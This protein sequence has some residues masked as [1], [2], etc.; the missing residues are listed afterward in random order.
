MKKIQE[1]KPKQDSSSSSTH[2][3]VQVVPLP[4]WEDIFPH[5]LE[6]MR[7]IEQ[8]RNNDEY[9]TNPYRYNL[10]R[11]SLKSPLGLSPLNPKRE[12][13]DEIGERIAKLEQVSKTCV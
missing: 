6:M 5:K 7:H 1:R 12:Q 8:R 9:P 3:S 13:P 10:C 11:S 2:E 4:N